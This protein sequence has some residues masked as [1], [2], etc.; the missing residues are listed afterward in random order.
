MLLLVLNVETVQHITFYEPEG[1]HQIL[2]MNEI[3]RVP[4]I[5][6]LFKGL[7]TPPA[8][9]EASVPQSNGTTVSFV[10]GLKRGPATFLF[11]W[12]TAFWNAP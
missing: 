12:D 2:H 3:T 6:H 1:I 5:D 8:T 10:D 11:F 7:R 4:V 9:P